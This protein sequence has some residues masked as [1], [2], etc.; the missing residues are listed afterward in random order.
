MIESEKLNYVREH[1]QELRVYKYMNLNA[2]NNDPETHGNEKEKRII[3]S[4]SFVG[5]HR[6][7]E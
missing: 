4:S 6:Y 3:L 5:S 2:Y 1:Q 7:M